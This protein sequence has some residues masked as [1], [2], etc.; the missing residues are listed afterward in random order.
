MM[1]KLCNYGVAGLGADILDSWRALAWGRGSLSAELEG[2]VAWGPFRKP[3]ERPVGSPS[4]V[5]A[6]AAELVQHPGVTAGAP[7]APKALRRSGQA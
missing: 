5:W 3:G 6:V 1:V 4:V 2:R 7:A